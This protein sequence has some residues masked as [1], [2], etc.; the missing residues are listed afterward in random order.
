M[1]ASNNAREVLEI[2]KRVAELKRDNNSLQL[3]ISE[4]GHELVAAQNRT[5]G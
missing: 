4:L 2:E 1:M 3:R 5:T